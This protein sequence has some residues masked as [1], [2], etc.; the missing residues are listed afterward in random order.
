MMERGKSYQ[1]VLHLLREHSRGTR[2]VLEIGC[3]GAQYKKFV[4]GRYIG[5]DLLDIHYDGPGPDV[6]AD[7]LHL[8]FQDNHFDFVFMVGVLYLISDVDVV[9][10]E[11]FR[12]LRMSGKLLVI[13]YN[14]PAT[15][16]LARM[17][18]AQFGWDTNVWSP[19]GLT[20]KLKEAGFASKIEWDYRR[21]SSKLFLFLQRFKLI[22]YLRFWVWQLIND[23]GIVSARK[24]ISNVGTKD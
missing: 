4:Q 14:L 20:R 13:D 11:I 17:N 5:V 7:G 18:Q 3:G 19:W 6:F 23:W 10:N 9:L 12:V 1:H 15:R 16:R 21:G 2:E 24:P 22:R 8:P